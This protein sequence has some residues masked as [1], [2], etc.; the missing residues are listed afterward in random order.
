MGETG[1]IGEYKLTTKPDYD[2]ERIDQLWTDKNDLFI[3][4]NCRINAYMLLKN[5]ITVDKDTYDDELLFLDIDAIENGE[6]FDNEELL[7][8][9][10]LFSRVETTNS[11]EKKTHGQRMG[12]FFSDVEFDPDV[13]VTSVVIHDNLDGDYLFVGHSGVLVEDDGGYLFIEK[14]SFSEPYQAIRFN[15]VEDCYRI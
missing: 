2:L 14:L 13:R 11:T 6:L 1:L 10:K 9:K 15:L 3:G 7:E 8:F 4:T 12:E 5:N